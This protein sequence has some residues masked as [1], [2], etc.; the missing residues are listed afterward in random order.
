MKLHFIDRSNL[1]ANSFTIKHNVYPNFLKIWHY[2][3]ELELV[4]ILKSTGTRFIGDSIEKFKEGEVVLIGENLPHM[5]LNEKKYFEEN[6]DLFAEAIAFHFKKDFLGSEIFKAPE[7]KDINLLIENAKFGLKFKKVNPE[8]KSRMQKLSQL[9]GF[10]RLLEFLQILSDLSQH[11]EIKFLSSTGFLNTF[12][13]TGNETL[14]N[15]YAYIFKNFTNQIT[16][17]DVATIA[18]M[19]A[20][21]FSRFFKRVNRKSFNEYLNEIRIGYACKLLTEHQYNITTICYESGFNNISNF[22]RQFKKITGKSPSNFL[23]NHLID[24]N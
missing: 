17:D 16:L 12:K 19:N 13:K 8:I 20:S 9:G 10:K 6:S 14:D 3:P 4:F 24:T 23:K 5:W 11:K 7:F 18:K 2:H 15:T 22:N 1:E 21:S